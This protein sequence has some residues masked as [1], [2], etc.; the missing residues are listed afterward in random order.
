MLLFP[1]FDGVLKLLINLLFEGLFFISTKDLLILYL[2]MWDWLFWDCYFLDG[3]LW[4]CILGL[5]LVCEG[6]CRV[7]FVYWRCVIIIFKLSIKYFMFTYYNMTAETSLRSRFYT[8]FPRDIIINLQSH[9]HRLSIN[10]WFNWLLF[11]HCLEWSLDI[12][13]SFLVALIW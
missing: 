7:F 12:C 3:S 6:Y 11:E 2:F 13:T 1:Q 8:N 10:T 4:G 9:W 5:I